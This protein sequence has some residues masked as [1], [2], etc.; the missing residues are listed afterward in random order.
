MTASPGTFRY[1]ATSWRALGSY[2]QLVV[3]GAD[4]LDAAR[5]V[6][7]R[8]LDQVDRSCSR[9]RADSDLVR[10][11]RSAGTRVRVDPM[12]AAAVQAALDAAASSDGLVDPTLGLA[13]VA[14]G[15]DRDFDD[16]LAGSA[17]AAVD[18]TDP[19]SI[20]APVVPEAWRQVEVDP[21]GALLVPAGVALDLGA[22]GKAFASDLIA[23]AIT[24][25]TGT[26]CVLSLGGDV[27]VG[28]GLPAPADPPPWQVAIS[29]TPEQP[30]AAVVT[31]RSGGM[32][33]STVLA[34][35][36]QHAGRA[37]HH[38]L[39][40]TTGRPVTP[41]WRTASVTAETC[42]VANTASTACIVLGSRAE[43]WLAA[44]GLAA[45]LV[46]ADGEVVAVGDWPAEGSECL[47]G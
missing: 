7:V 10:A 38:L 16:V 15:Y 45:R 40:P 18:P 3:D 6:A 14:V 36:W 46:G 25:E 4:R 21:D 23:A 20:P 42:L 34:R 8:L 47:T 37:V 5:A 24:A 35:R 29:E 1:A 11:N 31:L 33:T 27:A 9:F 19:A 13:L 2:V 44:R 28:P 39:D 26:G 17:A 32:A 41:V 30:P 22:T 43:G 12:L